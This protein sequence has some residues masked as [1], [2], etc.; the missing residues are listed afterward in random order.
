[1]MRTMR[2]T[3]Y[4]SLFCVLKSGVTSHGNGPTVRDFIFTDIRQ[5]ALLAVNAGMMR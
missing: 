5:T 1:M 3:Y 4:S 2:V